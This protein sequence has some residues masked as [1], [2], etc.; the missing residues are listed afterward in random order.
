MLNGTTL[1]SERR[2]EQARSHKDRIRFTD[3]EHHPCKEH[4][5]PVEQQKQ[6]L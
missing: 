3:I 5:T 1:S 2:P 4:A 6:S